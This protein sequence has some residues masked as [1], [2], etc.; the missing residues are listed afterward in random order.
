M[1]KSYYLFNFISVFGLILI[2]SC[3]GPFFSVQKDPDTIAPLLSISNPADQAIVKDSV[4]IALY[5]YDNDEIDTI[6]LYL[7]DEIIF[8][9]SEGDT[10]LYN[11]NTIDYPEDQFNSIWAYAVDVS[12][13]YNQTNTIRVKVNNL[14]DPDTTLP[15]GTIVYPANGQTVSDTIEIRVVAS[16]N[17]SI[18]IVSFYIEGDSVYQTSQSPYIYQWS[19]A[20]IDDDSYTIS[21]SVTDISQNQINIGPITLFV[22]NIPSPD[23]IAPTGNITFPPSGSFVSD[24]VIIQVSA[25]DDFGVSVVDFLVNGQSIGT[26]NTQPYKYSWDT[27]DEIE[28]S[29]CF[30][31]VILEDNSGNQSSLPTISVTINNIDD[32]QTPPMINIV[33]PAANQTVS[34]T[35]DIVAIAFDEFGIERVEF[36]QGGILA[37][38]VYEDPYI[39]S[40]NTLSENDDTEHIWSTIAYD[41]N[42]NYT[43]SQQVV[44]LVDNYDNIPPSGMITYPAAGQSLSGEIEIK[45][46]ANDNEG[47]EYVNFFINGNQVFSDSTAPYI[48]NWDTESETEDDNHTIQILIADFSGNETNLV[49]ITVYVDNDPYSEDVSPPLVSILNPLA[50]QILNEFVLISASVS[51]DSGISEVLFYI[52]DSLFNTDTDSPYSYLWDTQSVE[53]STDHVLRV[54]AIDYAGNEGNSQPILVTV[55]NGN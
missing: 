55:Q 20:E 53:D 40:W 29:E 54:S 42:G 5:A 25:Y 37:S 52:N 31:S 23:I 17:D 13:N 12:G 27:T 21:A 9:G 43:Y 50:G 10:V 33:S 28:D 8:S 32:D 39:F 51:D 7:N 47:V 38:T 16:D 11:W 18:S 1:T 22:D 41:N 46:S 24:T 4:T 49:P 3:E 44:L 26:D 15:T 2:V 45:V 48:Y 14:P 30:I 19:T 34:D 6:Q 36:F 35:T